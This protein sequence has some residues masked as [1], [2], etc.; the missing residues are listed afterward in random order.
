MK[1]INLTCKY[2]NT[3]KIYTKTSFAFQFRYFKEI[4]IFNCNQGCQHK[5]ASKHI[6]ISQI[7][8]IIITELHTENISGLLGLL[9][10]LSLIQRKKVLHIYSPKG[11]EKYLKLGKKY[12]QTNFHYNIYLHILK[13]GLIINSYTYQVYTFASNSKYEFHIT[14][15]EKY[16]KFKLYKAKNFSLIIGPLYGKLKKGSKFLLPD[17]YIL[18]GNSF[19]GNNNSGMK[20]SCILNKYHRRNS[21]EISTKSKVLKNIL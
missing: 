16:G 14:N 1:I 13:T 7:S 4:W 10:S 21:I 20:I 3:Y 2:T 19:T 8:R 18:D 6:R 5:L 17:G 15:K 11:L 12:S 9:S